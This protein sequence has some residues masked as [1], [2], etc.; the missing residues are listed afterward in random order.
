MFLL[1]VWD[2]LAAKKVD[3]ALAG[4]YAVALHGA[5]RG[6]LDIDLVLKATAANFAAAERALRSLGLES[7]LPIDASEAFSFR[8]EYVEK[9]NLIAWSFVNPRDGTEIVDLLLPYDLGRMK[10]KSI[11]FQN[12]K[13][14][15]LSLE[16]LIKMKSQ[17]GRKQDLEDVRA[18]KALKGARP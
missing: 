11:V 18:L 3:C 9:R 7:R 17:A 8:F 15:I 12:R 16:E 4:G 6:T 5:V 1:K 10:T 14:R 13:L 2:E